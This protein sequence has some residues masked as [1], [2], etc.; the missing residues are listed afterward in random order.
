MVALKVS[1]SVTPMTVMVTNAEGDIN[2]GNVNSD[3][4]IS[5]PIS[6]L[7]HVLSSLAAVDDVNGGEVQ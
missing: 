7:S 1:H 6:S 4:V 5:V 3:A 2:N